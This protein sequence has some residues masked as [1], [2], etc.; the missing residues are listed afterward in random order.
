MDHTRKSHSDILDLESRRKIYDLV[1]QYAGYHMREIQ[2]A[3]GMP[4][5]TVSYHLS[6]LQKHHLIR[7][8][9]D[10]NH[11]RYYPLTMD[12]HNERILALLRQRSVRNI[13]FSIMAHDG[14]SHQD[15]VSSIHLS[16]STTTWH[17][18]KLL[19]SDI[20]RSERRGKYNAYL[21]NV[22][23]ES[24]MNLLITFRESFLD[25]LVDGLL[26]LWE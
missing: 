15:I 9:R 11:L 26:E 8:E 2:R 14:C 10:G 23:K 4:F 16:P 17:L 5:G 25:C 13:L 19:D 3:S 20:I 22:P 7:E 18:K 24:I 12:I 21:L 1:R 6:Y